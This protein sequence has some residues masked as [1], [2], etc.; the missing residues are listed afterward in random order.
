MRAA[1]TV[2]RKEAVDALRDRRTLAVV[3]LSSV[4]MGPLVLVALSALVASL[5]A[6]AERREVFVDGIAHAPS[7]VNFLERQTFVVREPPADV[8]AGLRAGRFADPVIVVP[9]DFEGRL[10]RGEVPR[11]EVVGDSA[12]QRA[13]AATARVLRLL[14]AFGRERAT[15]AL[16]LR[17]VAAELIAPIEVDERDL[18]SAQAQATRL[19]GVLPFFVLMA[20]LYGALTAALDSTAGERERGSLEPLLANP[21]PPLAI[22]LGKWGAVAGVAM[23]IALLAC[24]SFLPTQWLLASDT[25]AAMFR[26]GPREALLFLAVLLP[27]AAMAAALLMAVAI[28][29][30]TVKEAQASAA[31][32][33]LVASLLPLVTI[34]SPGGDAAWQLWVPALGQ[35]VLMLR[36]LK[37][38]TIGAAQALPPLVAC[39]AVAGLALRDVAL[40]LRMAALR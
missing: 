25:L 7:L 4:L 40:R 16:A 33:I 17:G 23:L 18:A 22:V 14:D 19:T 9:A 10:A 28:R 26:F 34:F 29:C 6:R 13:S 38:E 8:E 35:S 21:V 37:G 1:W 11:I 24:A 15:L 30:R 3:L 12:N 20:V 36:V 2:L 39:I 5:E 31:V 27:F 32:V